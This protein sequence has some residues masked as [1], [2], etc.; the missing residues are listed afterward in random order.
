MVADVRNDCGRDVHHDDVRDETLSKR[1]IQQ[2]N[3][4]NSEECHPLFYCF[5]TTSHMEPPMMNRNLKDL[6]I[7]TLTGIISM[8]PG[9]SGATILVIFGLYERLIRDLA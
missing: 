6:M 2:R 1:I 4:W 8:L 5:Y 9:A 7:G 3:E